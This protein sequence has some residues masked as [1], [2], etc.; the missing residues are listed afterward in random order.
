MGIRKEADLTTA[1]Y[2]VKLQALLD[3]IEDTLKKHNIP[4]HKKDKARML[5]FGLLCHAQGL[6]EGVKVYRKEILARG[7][8]LFLM[9]TELERLALKYLTTQDKA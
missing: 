4:Y 5:V 2:S 6:R 9:E 7:D 8:D 3:M 1:G